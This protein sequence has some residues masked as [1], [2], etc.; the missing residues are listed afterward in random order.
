MIFAN[1]DPYFLEIQNG[2]TYLVTS[3]KGDVVIEKQL[4][5]G[6][7]YEVEGSPVADGEERYMKT[8]SFLENPDTIRKN[9]Y[10]RVTPSA[11]GVIFHAKP[12]TNR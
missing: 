3:N 1:T 5:D 7:F 6:L 4:E 10:V 11:A 12:V 2:S 8:I 9:P